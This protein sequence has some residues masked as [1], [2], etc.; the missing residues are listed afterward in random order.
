VHN[1]RDLSLYGNWRNW[2]GVFF[3]EATEGYAGVYSEDTGLGVARIYPPDL[4]PG[5]K[6]FGFGAEF[7][8]RAEFSDDGSDYF[9]LWGGPCRSFWA[10]DDLILAASQSVTWREVW[11]PFSGLG[12]LTYANAN[13]AVFASIQDTTVSLSI[14]PSRVSR[15]ELSVSWN[16]AVLHQ[17]QVALDPQRVAQLSLLLPAGAALP[18]ELQVELKDEGAGLLR[19]VRTLGSR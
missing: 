16:G 19:F 15:S 14:A 8:A 3:P 11:L 10:E 4:A 18:G 17:G 2:L 7:P 9:E 6:L 13:A 12:G 1:G 5:L